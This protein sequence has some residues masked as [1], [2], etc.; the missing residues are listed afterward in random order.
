MKLEKLLCLKYVGR[1]RRAN[2]G[3]FQTT[4]L[5]LLELHDTI[6]SVDESSTMSYVFRRNGAGPLL[7]PPPVQAALAMVP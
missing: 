7:G 3:G 2:S 6:S 4:K 1:R 5:V